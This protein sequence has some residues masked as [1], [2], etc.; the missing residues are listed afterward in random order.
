M[1]NSESTASSF[2]FP[3]CQHCGILGTGVRTVDIGAFAT[4][5]QSFKRRS[6]TRKGCIYNICNHFNVLTNKNFWNNLQYTAVFLVAPPRERSDLS[7]HCGVCMV[8]CCLVCIHSHKFY[9]MSK[10]P[11]PEHVSHHSEQL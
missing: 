2:T 10:I 4:F 8:G 6:Q 9:H 3:F 1:V 5:F 7:G 11:K